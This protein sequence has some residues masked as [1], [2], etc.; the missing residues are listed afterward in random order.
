MEQKRRLSKKQLAL[1]LSKL[2]I[3]QNPRLQLEQY[4][5]SSNVASELLYMAG[6]EHPELE[7]NV[8]DLGTGTGRLAI[9]AAL[10]GAKH[11][12]GID[13]DEKLIELARE[14]AQSV[15][16][17]V[18]WI[19]SDISRVKG[20]YDTAIMNPPYGTRISHADARFL[21]KSFDLAPIVY[22]IHKASTRKFLFEFVN[23]ANRKV[24]EV[25]EMVLQI[26]HSFS[27]HRRKWRDVN[28]DIY[29]IGS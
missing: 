23:R 17:N 18:Q 16:V 15:G 21:K 29:R 10:M 12:V 13:T 19:A 27:F 8:I 3:P 14:N 7:G 26:P 9:G 22:S 24:L 20:S 11:V 5:V 4:P 6:F 28:V 2:K 1:K 25:R